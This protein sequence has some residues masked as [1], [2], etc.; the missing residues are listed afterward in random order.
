MVERLRRIAQLRPRLPRPS[1][2]AGAAGSAL[3]SVGLWV[4][5]PPLG[6]IAAGVFL[7]LID[8]RSG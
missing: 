5:W 8:E 3:V 1:W 2:L 4:A 6:L 7:L